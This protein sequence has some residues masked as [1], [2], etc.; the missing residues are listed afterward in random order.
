M[1]RKEKIDYRTTDFSR[2]L[3]GDIFEHTCDKWTNE[4]EE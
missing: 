4:Y 2:F 1:A 3:V